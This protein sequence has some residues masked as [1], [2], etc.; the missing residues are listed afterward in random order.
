MMTLGDSTVAPEPAKIAGIPVRSLAMAAN[1]AVTVG[2][3]RK[4]HPVV[5]W[6]FGPIALAGN[7]I[8]TVAGK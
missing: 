6:L 3:S 4:R 5:Y 8:L 1:L 2:V 7:V